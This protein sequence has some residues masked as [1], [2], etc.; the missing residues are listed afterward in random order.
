MLRIIKC[1][2]L[3]GYFDE[4]GNYHCTPTQVI[5]SEATAAAIEEC[6]NAWQAEVDECNSQISQYQ[7]LKNEIKQ[8]IEEA[9]A[10][11]GEF[12][13]NAGVLASANVTHPDTNL[14]GCENCMDSLVTAYDGM[15]SQCDSEIESW[16]AKKAQAEAKKGSCPADTPKVYKTV[17]L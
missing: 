9:N 10:L 1:N 11:H 5:D 15:M 13:A 8:K 7:D 6:E 16:Q 17:C 4:S 3:M 2:K 14:A 12:T